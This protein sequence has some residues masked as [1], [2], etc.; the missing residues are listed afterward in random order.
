MTCMI[1]ATEAEW[2]ASL[3]AHE[4]LMA[5]NDLFFVS[6]DSCPGLHRIH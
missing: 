6:P 1:I 5:Q 2:D 4:W 3:A